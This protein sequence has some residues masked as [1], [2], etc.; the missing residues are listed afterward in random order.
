MVQAAFGTIAGNGNAGVSISPTWEGRSSMHKGER[1][2]S[3]STR[4]ASTGSSST[5]LDST[6]S[7]SL[8]AHDGP[9]LSL[10]SSTTSA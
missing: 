9:S 6:A 3:D 4:P 7:S 2:S 8:R 5:Q 10:L 1:H